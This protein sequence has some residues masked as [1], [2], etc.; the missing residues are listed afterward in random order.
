MDT[1][2]RPSDALPELTK[3]LFESQDQ[4]REILKKYL[5]KTEAPEAAGELVNEIEYATQ[6]TASTIKEVGSGDNPLETAA[7]EIADTIR[8]LAES[9]AAMSSYLD[10]MEK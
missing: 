10:R 7:L 4:A 3:M 1:K 2:Q 8:R 5:A 9:T 6:I